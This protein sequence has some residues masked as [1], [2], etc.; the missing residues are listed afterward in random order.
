MQDE[1]QV[2]KHRAPNGALRRGRGVCLL[3]CEYPRQKS[4]GAKWCIKTAQQGSF[5]LPYCGA[6]QKA[7]SA[8]RCIKTGCDGSRTRECWFVRKHRAPN[9]ALRLTDTVFPALKNAISQKAP[10][11]KRCI[12]TKA[13]E[14]AN[15]DERDVSENTERQKVH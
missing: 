2:R 7:P 10:S 11:A 12:K 6:C 8:K 9:G 4:P 14:D 3:G 5:F 1:I 13:H 15:A